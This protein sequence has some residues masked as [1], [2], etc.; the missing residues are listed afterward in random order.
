MTILLLE[1]MLGSEGHMRENTQWTEV[2][3]H[4]MEDDGCCHL[5]G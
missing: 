3:C 4:F 5:R 2:V 1:D